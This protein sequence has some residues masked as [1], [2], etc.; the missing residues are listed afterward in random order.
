[1]CFNFS[2]QSMLAGC[3]KIRPDVYKGRL[4]RAMARWK[5]AMGE[6]PRDSVA[7][8][9]KVNPADSSESG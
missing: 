1:M 9:V 3:I 6:D 4:W 8:I 2:G 7:G 5:E